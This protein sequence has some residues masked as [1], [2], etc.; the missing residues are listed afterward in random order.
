[1]RRSAGSQFD[2]DVVDAF[3]CEI[4]NA[5]EEREL[6]AAEHAAAHVRTLLGAK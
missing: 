4:E 5:A 3:L 1:L 6:N 2:P